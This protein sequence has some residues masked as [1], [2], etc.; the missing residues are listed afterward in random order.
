MVGTLV[1]IDP[2]LSHEKAG[3]VGRVALK[4]NY[5]SDVYIITFPDE[6]SLA[7]RRD[8]FTVIDLSPM[9]PA[10]KDYL[11][12]QNLLQWLKK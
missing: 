5:T 4:S 10:F 3:S 11:T 9:T 7:F 8:E 12:K 2:D 6:E 1:L